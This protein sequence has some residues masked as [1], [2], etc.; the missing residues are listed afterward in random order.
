MG[1][2]SNPRGAESSWEQWEQDENRLGH[3]PSSRLGGCQAPSS[4]SS[5]MGGESQHPP[6]PVQGFGIAVSQ[7]QGLTQLLPSLSSHCCP[8]T[9]QV[10][11]RSI[12]AMCTL[13]MFQ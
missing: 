9:W 10:L 3:C 6:L 8:I 12:M 13:N 11:T 4:N 5:E 1:S 2:S 7:E